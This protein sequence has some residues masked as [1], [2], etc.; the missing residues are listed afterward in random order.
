MLTHFL[1]SC[2]GS[3]VGSDSAFQSPPIFGDFPFPPPFFPFF[4][5]IF[6]CGHILL[7]EALSVH[8]SGGHAN[9]RSAKM[10]IYDGTV[11]NVCMCE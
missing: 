10:C 4:P 5:V 7:K 1:A 8:W 2:T 9:V 6:S 3:K 11:V